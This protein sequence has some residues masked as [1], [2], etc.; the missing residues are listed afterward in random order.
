MPRPGCATVGFVGSLLR[1][2]VSRVEHLSDRARSE[3]AQLVDGDPLVNAVISARLRRVRTLDASLFGGDVLGVR[4]VDGRLVAAAVYGANLLPVGQAADVDEWRILG[5]HVAVR[6]RMCTTIVGRAESVAAMWPALAGSWGPARAVRNCQPLL[7]LDRANCPRTGDPQV[8]AVRPDELERYLPAA[9][10]MFAE[11]LG[12]A[13]ERTCGRT[14]YRRRVASLIANEQA[15]AIFDA[16][17]RVVF[18]ADLG[19]VSPHTC[20]VHGVWVRPELRGQ[21]IGGAALAS[22]LRRAL[23]LAPTVSLYVNDFNMSARRIYERLGMRE[24]ATLSTVLF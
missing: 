18:K 17:G 20:Q 24:A 8:R 9:A 4:D 3:F 5:E 23:M 1:R 13:P 19:A 11:E 15:F 16:A 22:V 2:T 12:I 6:R 14:E 21:G 10:A 7:V